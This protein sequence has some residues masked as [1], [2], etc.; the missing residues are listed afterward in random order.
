MVLFLFYIYIY[1]FILQWVLFNT[2]NGVEEKSFINIINR[3][4]LTNDGNEVMRNRLQSLSDRFR[5][6]FLYN[7]EEIYGHASGTRMRINHQVK[8]DH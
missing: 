3:Q 2:I 5:L 7:S 1:I 6:N 4:A 8:N